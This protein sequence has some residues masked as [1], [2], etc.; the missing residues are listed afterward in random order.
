MDGASG[1]V[2][3]MGRLSDA[4]LAAWVSASCRAQGVPVK[5]T[6][7]AVV[8]D[9]CVLLGSA[10]PGRRPAR[11]RGRRPAGGASEAPDGLNPV[12]VERLGSDDAWADDGVVEDGG[13]DGVLSGEVEPGPLRA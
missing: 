7:S 13:D 5:V 11:Q 9:V 3:V 2:G 12:W 6:D 1:R 8:R 10:G 4:E